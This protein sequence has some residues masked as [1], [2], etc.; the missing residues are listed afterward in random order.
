MA[1]KGDTGE[2]LVVPAGTYYR[3]YRVALRLFRP[4]LGSC[5]DTSIYYEHKLK[6]A[7][8]D[9]KRANKLAEK[10]GKRLNKETKKWVGPEITDDKEIKELTACV[11]SY[12]ALTGI[13][14][15]I[16]TDK[17]ELL[18]YAKDLQIAHDEMIKQGESEKYTVFM[19]DKDGMPII[20]SHMILG[21]LK[22]NLRIITNNTTDGKDDKAAKS[23][24]AVG[25]MMAL[26]VKVVEEFLEPV[27]KD[28]KRVDIMRK[29]TG[30]KDLLKLSF[31]SVEE[32]DSQEEAVRV[33]QELAKGKDGKLK[34]DICERPLH[35]SIKGQPASA[36]A[37]S[38]QLPPDTEYHFHL[39]V[40]AKSPV[41]TALLKELLTYGKNNG[42]G[43]WRGSGNKGA[44]H[45]Q[46][47][48]IKDDP[49]PIPEGW[50]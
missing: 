39:R 21:N 11:R 17:E 50:S 25:E 26:D 28:G 18:A 19:R 32:R 6:K 2:D 23:K 7:K 35:F 10:I 15:D 30:E 36:I 20:S 22:E 47:E 40:R 14:G 34:P 37:L 24:V 5:P 43:P 12:Q 49:T 44:F 8:D 13:F 41:S 46:I 1:K 33:E 42:L 45:Y 16:P 4:Q 29:T 27:D 48:E 31:A 3:Y 9:I 38:E